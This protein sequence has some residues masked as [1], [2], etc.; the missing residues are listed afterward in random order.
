MVY[1]FRET[2]RERERGRERGEGE[3]DS[4]LYATIFPW[5]S[6]EHAQIVS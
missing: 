1:G 5:K 2:E 4:L 6:I 3:A